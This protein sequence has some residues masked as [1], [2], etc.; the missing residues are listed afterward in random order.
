MNVSQLNEALG[1][2]INRLKISNTSTDAL[3]NEIKR[4]KA[5]AEVARQ[6]ID[7]NKVALEAMK[8]KADYHGSTAI[9]IPSQMLLE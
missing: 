4:S 2:Q 7:N 8:L 9:N 3:D 5:M 6:I 1:E